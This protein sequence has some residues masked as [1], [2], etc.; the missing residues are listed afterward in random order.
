MIYKTTHYHIIEVNNLQSA[1]LLVYLM[2]F[3]KISCHVETF[4][5][6]PSS[7]ETVCISRMPS[8]GMW[9]SHLLTLVPRSRIFFF[10]LLPWRW[11]RYGPPVYTIST[12]R[13]IPEDGILH[14][15]RRQNLKS[16]MCVYPLCLCMLFVKRPCSISSFSGYCGLYP[17]SAIVQSNPFWS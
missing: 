16:Y 1:F 6:F 8:S 12:R 13:H 10:F 15:H 3:W 14:S 7:W 2:I 11:R 9:R 4:C 5:L 17:L